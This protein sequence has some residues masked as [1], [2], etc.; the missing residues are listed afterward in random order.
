MKNALMIINLICYL[1]YFFYSLYFAQI[2]ERR[3][4]RISYTVLLFA[5][6]IVLIT[7]LIPN[8]ARLYHENFEDTYS[9]QRILLAFAFAYKC[10]TDFICQIGTD[11]FNAAFAVKHREVKNN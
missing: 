9:W 11:K 7:F 5:V 1:I 6:S 3:I 8:D 10:V 4:N 2:S